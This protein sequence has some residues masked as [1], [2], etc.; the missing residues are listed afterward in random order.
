MKITVKLEKEEF[1]K[2]IT[3]SSEIA[4]EIDT[5]A[6]EFVSDFELDCGAVKLKSEEEG[7]YDI[8]IDSKFVCWVLR[9]S[10]SFMRFTKAIV[11][12]FSDFIDDASVFFKE[13]EFKSLKEESDEPNQY[14]SF[15]EETSDTTSTD[16]SDDE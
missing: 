7:T 12:F 13:P 11:T 10:V 15:D 14:N 2:L 3:T 4:S 9:K 16:D 5:D 1:H 6:P 8:D